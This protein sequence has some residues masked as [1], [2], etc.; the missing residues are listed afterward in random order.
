MKLDS[1]GSN[2]CHGYIRFTDGAKNATASVRGLFIGA[3]K[4]NP[5]KLKKY[6]FSSQTS[7]TNNYIFIEGRISNTFKGLNTGYSGAP[8]QLCSN[9]ENFASVIAMVAASFNLPGAIN[10]STP[11]GFN[12]VDYTHGVS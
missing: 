3:D 1:I 8:V 2:F 11:I 6:V 5:T 10:I 12:K 4:E 9:V 7:A